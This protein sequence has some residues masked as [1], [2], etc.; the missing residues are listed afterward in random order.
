VV[1]RQTANSWLKKIQKDAIAQTNDDDGDKKLAAFDRHAVTNTNHKSSL[2]TKA[3]R[4][5]LQSVIKARDERN[6]GMPRKEVISVIAEIA[7]VPVKNAENHL[8]YLIRSKKLP[9]L[10]NNGRIVRAQATTTNRTAVTTE[11]LLR[12]HMSQEEGEFC[13][14]SFYHYYL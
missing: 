9:E 11:K 5:F 8:D 1:K 7:S 10:K 3:D 2:T 13:M 12:T 6:A 14:F 4:D